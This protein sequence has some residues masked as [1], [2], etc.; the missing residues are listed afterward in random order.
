MEIR[1]GPEGRLIVRAPY[2]P[3]V[4]FRM[5]AVRDRAWVREEQHWHVPEGPG[6]VRWLEALFQGIDAQIHASL[7]HSGRRPPPNRSRRPPV[8]E[9]RRPPTT[10]PPRRPRRA[11]EPSGEAGTLYRAMA[12]ELRLRGYGAKTRKA[13]LGHLRRLFA[14]T[15]AGGGSPQE[16]GEEELR[17]Y[18]LH[19]L[20]EKGASH[21]YASQSVSALKFFYEHGLDRPS[22][23]LRLPRPKRERKLPVVLSREEVRR[24]LAA[25]EHPKHRAILMLVYAAGLRVGEVVRLRPEDVDPERRLLHV[26]QAKGRKDRYVMLSEVALE[27]VDIYARAFPP[28]RWLFPGARDGRHLHERSVQHIFQKARKKAGVDKPASVHTFRHC[29]ATHLLENGVD[30]RYIQEMLGHVS[31]KTTQIYAHVTKLQL[32]RIRSPLD[33]LMSGEGDEADS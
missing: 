24:I 23:S 6:T 11:P 13:Y 30:L 12:E 18:V 4:V 26:R 33:D 3:E 15:E 19:L 7:R 21:A 20:E 31:P 2:H 8:P 25:V 27:A 32:A 14:W 22:G 28:G 16:V 10:R 9:P 5:K 29:F 1:P 17:R